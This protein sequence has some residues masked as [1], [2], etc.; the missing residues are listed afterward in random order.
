MST[1]AIALADTM[2]IR[3][4]LDPD[5]QLAFGHVLLRRGDF[6]AAARQFRRVIAMDSLVPHEDGR[7][8]KCDAYGYL[9]WS[10]LFADSTAAATHVMRDFAREYP[11]IDSFLGSEMTL[12]R[13]GQFSEARRA[14]LAVDSLSHGS[15]V[16]RFAMALLS[17]RQGSFADADARL[18]QLARDGDGGVRDEANWDSMISLRMQ[19]V[20]A[21]ALQLATRH[22]VSHHPGDRVV[23][24]GSRVRSGERFPVAGGRHRLDAHRQRGEASARGAHTRGDQPSGCRSTARLAR[25]ADSVEWIG[26][27]SMFGRDPRL[28]YYIRGLLWNARLEPRRAA[29]SFRKSIWS[30][31]E[32][33]TRANFELWR[34]LY[35][36]SIR[37]A[38]ACLRCT[39]SKR[40][41]AATCRRAICMSREPS[42]TSS[43]QKP[44][45]EQAF[46]TALSRTTGR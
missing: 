42:F 14:L 11:T 31:S 21:E 7:C 34:G 38:V 37:R 30:W 4:P 2:A 27:L 9:A 8:L 36:L 28:H 12:A 25:L 3:Y 13:A 41:C 20:C 17:L 24:G 19:G 45:T 10:Y 1:K 32:G 39:H 23:G 6:T 5:A 29:E 43:W 40:P 16:V 44:S 46:V 18:L 26:Q 15:T 22:G 35:W 33:Y